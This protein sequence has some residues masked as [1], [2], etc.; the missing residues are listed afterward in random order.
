LTLISVP[1]ICRAPISELPSSTVSAFEAQCCAAQICDAPLFAVAPSLT[2]TWQERD[3]LV[4]L[5]GYSVC[6]VRSELLLIGSHQAQSQ[7]AVDLCYD[8]DA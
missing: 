8:Q 6:R 3:S 7:R 2:P 1:Q 5:V 4:V